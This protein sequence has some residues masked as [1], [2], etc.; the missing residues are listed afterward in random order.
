MEK[1][2]V[3]QQ[4]LADWNVKYDRLKA[5]DE[6]EIDEGLECDDDRFHSNN[7]K[8]VK[9]L[10]IDMAER[11]IQKM[12]AEDSLYMGYRNNNDPAYDESA[13]GAFG[14]SAKHWEE[15]YVLFPQ[16]FPVPAKLVADA[17]GNKRVFCVNVKGTAERVGEGFRL[18][19][20]GGPR[21]GGRKGRAE[22]VAKV[23][24]EKGFVF[25][26]KTVWDIF[27]SPLLVSDSAMRHLVAEIRALAS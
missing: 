1:L 19:E 23:M 11:V 13:V 9:V 10:T 6:D 24:A 26:E 7:S 15:V 3:A 5:D 25:C 21:P 17:I 18:F 14:F 22:T 20:V 8:F 12:R 4:E 2:S 16:S 27:H